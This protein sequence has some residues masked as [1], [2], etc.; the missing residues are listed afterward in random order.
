M[1]WL[2]RLKAS[3]AERKRK[4][5]EAMAEAQRDQQRW[6]DMRRQ[7]TTLLYGL[8]FDPN[9]GQQSWLRLAQL[10]REYKDSI[11]E[12][13]QRVDRLEQERDRT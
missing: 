12:L 8:G 11:Q 6:Y 5:L 9:D 4:V 13:Q 1:L 2:T 3:E 10:L 7:E